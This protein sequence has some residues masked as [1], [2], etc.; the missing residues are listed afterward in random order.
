MKKEIIL[1]IFFIIILN[2]S[3]INCSDSSSSG[4]EKEK[5]EE[6]NLITC[7]NGISC[8][9]KNGECIKDEL[10][11]EYIC[12]CKNG[13]STYPENSETKCNY[14]Q[15]TQIKAFLLEFFLSY[16]AG[17]FYI[18]N[19]KLAIPKLIVFAFFYCLFIVL[20]IITKAKEENKCANLI[21]CICAGITFV[22]MLFWQ[23]TDLIIFGKNK[24][25]DGKGV[26]L[27][28]W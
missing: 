5:E 11:E 4:K 6:G 28:P 25:K 23:I 9:S 1:K 22:G 20:R 18:Q 2:L 21:I 24:Y 12:L 3:L 15:K 7:P 14:Q 26:S 16:G 27:K 10:K 8:N 19:Y 13:Y 17:H